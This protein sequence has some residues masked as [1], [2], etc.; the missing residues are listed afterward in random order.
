MQDET[1]NGKSEGQRCSTGWVK[2][3]DP[4]GNLIELVQFDSLSENH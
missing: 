4:A 1:N 2:F 3:Y